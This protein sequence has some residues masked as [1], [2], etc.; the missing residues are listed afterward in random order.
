MTEVEGER[1]L[2]AADL[3]HDVQR[4]SGE[5]G[6]LSL[7]QSPLPKLRVHDTYER[8]QLAAGIKVIRR[9]LVAQNLRKIVQRTEQ[10]GLCAV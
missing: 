7:R 8:V 4:L 1:D 5:L 10:A 9:V 2:W 3:R 6:R